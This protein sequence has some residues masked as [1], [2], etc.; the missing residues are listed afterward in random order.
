MVVLSL[1]SLGF[2]PSREASKS[3]CLRFIFQTWYL[4]DALW[5]G[6]EV[7][8]I[9]DLFA[10]VLGA[11]ETDSLFS[12]SV[13]YSLPLSILRAAAAARTKS[14]VAHVGSASVVAFS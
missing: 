5:A 13:I 12:I 14:C 9:Y 4:I 11:L 3:P 6:V 10:M 2:P 1:L 7:I 8:L